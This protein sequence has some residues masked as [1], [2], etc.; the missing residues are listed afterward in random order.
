MTSSP[1]G[2]SLGGPTEWAIEGPG[3]FQFEGRVPSD[4][5][6]THRALLLGS[7]GERPLRILR[8]LDSAD[9]RATRAAV[10][11]LGAEV[12]CEAG[13]WT[14][15][16]APWCEPTDVI[17]CANSGTTLRLLTGLL[18]AG[19]GLAVLTG[20]PSLRRRPMGRVVEPLR[21]LGAR[22]DGREDGRKAPLTI[23]GRAID[24]GHRIQLTVASAQVKSAVLLA[25]LR[26]G[27]GVAIRECGPT[28]DHTE[29]MLSAAGRPVARRGS[30]IELASGDGPLGFPETLPVPGD[31]SSAVF[32]LVAAAIRPGGRATVHDVGLNPTRTG[33]LDV[34]RASGATV[35]VR[36]EH[37]VAGERLGTVE[38]G[39]PAGPLRPFRISGETVVRAIDE[40]PALAVLAAVAQGRSEFREAAELRV[41]ESDR[42]RGIVTG[43]EAFGARI[44]EYPDGFAIEGGAGLRGARVDSRGDHRLAMAF[45][46]AAIVAEGETRIVDPACIDVSFPGFSALWQ[47]AME[48]S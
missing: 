13:V 30:W 41:K 5:S 16:P 36:D 7:L 40:L 27:V 24:G 3:G 28:R 47:R 8:P 11:Q 14:L 32:P 29:R 22:I 19:P 12:Q 44:E 46:C 33:A 25:A 20:D 17:D 31:I 6:I 18:A 35:E 1:R 4:K 39:A 42:I 15:A 48:S 10:Q 26:C 45:A 34:L 21:Q 38:V 2:R 23:R 43:L 9:T 37:E